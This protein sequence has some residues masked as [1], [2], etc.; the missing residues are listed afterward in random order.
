MTMLGNMQPGANPPRPIFAGPLALLASTDIEGFPLQNAT[1]NIL[2]WTAPNDGQMHRVTVSGILG[3]SSA[4]TGGA[5]TLEGTSP[6]GAFAS[7][8]QGGTQG[9][10]V[11]ALTSPGFLAVSSGTTVTLQQ[12]SAVTAGAGV[13]YAELWGS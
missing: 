12:T 9:A 4:T 8:I 6:A 11:H 13:V 2:T 3:V 5:I 7:S 10:G 1:P